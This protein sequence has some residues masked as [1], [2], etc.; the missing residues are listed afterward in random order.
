[1]SNTSV[2]HYLCD[3]KLGDPDHEDTIQKDII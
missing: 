1:M 3:I 2:V